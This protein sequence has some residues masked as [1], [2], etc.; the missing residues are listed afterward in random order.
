MGTCRVMSCVP[1]KAPAICIHFPHTS[2]TLKRLV[3]APPGH[4]ASS[5]KGAGRGVLS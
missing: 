4:S 5:L 2:H 1:N 3:L